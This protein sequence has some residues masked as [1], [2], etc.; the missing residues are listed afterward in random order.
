MVISKVIEIH[1]ILKILNKYY[2][3][4][5]YNLI[6]CNKTTINTTNIVLISIKINN[7]FFCRFLLNFCWIVE[8]P[9]IFSSPIFTF[10]ITFFWLGD[11]WSTTKWSTGL[12]CYWKEKKLTFRLFVLEKWSTDLFCYSIKSKF[13][14]FWNFFFFFQW[15]CVFGFNW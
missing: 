4:E 14:F 6:L 7:L 3:F 13:L 11:K 9:T 5:W 15:K 1:W 12:F 10:P 2:L 8:Y